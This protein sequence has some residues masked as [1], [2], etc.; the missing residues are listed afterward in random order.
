MSRY[1]KQDDELEMTKEEIYKSFK[2]AKSK[3]QQIAILADLNMTSKRHIKEIIDEC[4]HENGTHEATEGVKTAAE[5]TRQTSVPLSVFKACVVYSDRLKEDIIELNQN[6]KELN[7]Q[8][9]AK[10][11]ELEELSSYI[12]EDS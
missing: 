12:G 6:I 11:S 3:T 1:K 10:K 4:E 8:L 9:K 2:E 7:E 5:P